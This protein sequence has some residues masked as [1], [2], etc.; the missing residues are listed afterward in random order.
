MKSNYRKFLSP[1]PP[2]K[3]NHWHNWVKGTM[4]FTNTDHSYLKKGIIFFL[5]IIVMV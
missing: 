5:L 2:K 1:P 4:D 3:K